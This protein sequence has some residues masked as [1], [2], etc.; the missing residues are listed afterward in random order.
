M[1]STTERLVIREIRN[2]DKKDLIANIND[3]D[4]STNLLAVHYPYTDKNAEDWINQCKK[5]AREKPRRNY[6][7]VIEL[8][9]EK[10]VIGEIGLVNVDKFQGTTE[11]AYW[12]GENYWRKGFMSEALKDVLDFAFKK[13]KLRR[14]NFYIFKENRA[15]RNLAE[16]IGFKLEGMER[17]SVRSRADGKIHDDAIYGLLKEG[18]IK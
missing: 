1:K 15:S 9:L 4:V 17:K 6:N 10:R 12:L 18:W 3:L 11:I 16:K 14:I 7:L 13:L 2:E 5:E 8:K